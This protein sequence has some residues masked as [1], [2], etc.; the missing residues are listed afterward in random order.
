MR[1]VPIKYVREGMILGKTLYGNNGEVLLKKESPIHLSYVKRLI[2][3]GYCGIY[4]N[5]ELSEDITVA[6]VIS[7]DL[8]MRTIKSIKN[9]MKPN[10]T[11]KQVQSSLKIIE[12]LMGNIV[13]EI[14]GNEDIMVNMMDLRV[15]SEYTFYHS[16]NVCILSMV[17]GVALK[18]K[19]EDLYLLGTA[20]LLHDI[21]KIYTPNEILDKPAK[22][23]YE[24]F[25]IIKQHSQNGYSYIKE[26]LYI[27][28]KVYM[29]IYQHHENYN[30]T[31][32]PLSIKGKK[33]S[34]FG[35]IIAI[36]DVYDALVSDRPYRKG[37]LPSEAIEYIMGGGGTMFDQSLVK[38]F[39]DKI[40]PYP[41]G[42]CVKLSNNLI[43]IVVKNYSCYCLRPSVKILQSEDK[44]VSPYLINLKDSNYNVTIVDMVDSLLYQ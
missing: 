12:I 26:N 32:Y 9:L 38:I 4:I 23:T 21:G 35:R 11:K 28:T 13:D 20:A 3:L 37:V 17:L 18:F 30:G 33:I 1:Y 8:K 10:R 24:E 6:E 43:G 27:N 19:K 31:G 25:E 41:I 22:L 7:E 16:V 39:S 15:A 2:Y 42:T 44:L 29:G 40:A 34:L 14:S 5:D 36:A